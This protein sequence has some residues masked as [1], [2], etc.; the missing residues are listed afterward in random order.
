MERAKFIEH[1]PLTREALK[2]ASRWHEGQTR[3]IGDIPFVT[4]PVE[5][6]CLLHEAGYADEVVAAGVLHDVLEDT[7]VTRGELE[8]RF[9]PRV[10]ELVAAVSEDPSIEDRAE[11]KAALRA[12][13]A[14]AGEDAAGV[15][16]ADKISKTRELR[17]RARRGRFDRR[18][19]AKLEH[20]EASLDLLSAAL[21][22]SQL[23]ERLRAELEQLE[24][25]AAAR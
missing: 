24:P 16:A 23:V 3:D 9:G 25:Q 5:V 7:E 4:H 22:G 15:F 8:Q 1:S 2:L 21:P 11:R 19:R 12:Q 14:A 10:A 6:A 13:V 18:D 17:K 20:Y